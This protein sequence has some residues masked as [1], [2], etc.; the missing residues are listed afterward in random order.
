MRIVLLFI[1]FSICFSNNISIA[2]ESEA[3]DFFNKYVNLSNQWSLDLID[4]YAQNALIKRNILK[5]QPELVNVPLDEHK[6][7]LKNYNK[8]QYLLIGVKN[9]YNVKSVNS[10]SN[11]KYKI[12]AQRCPSIMNRCFDCY[13]IIQ[14]QNGEFKITEEYSDVNSRYFLKFKDKK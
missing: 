12:T 5:K 1:I 14:K 4:M 3:R 9:N 2:A 8:Y 11:N 13:M 7:M 6:K 10:L